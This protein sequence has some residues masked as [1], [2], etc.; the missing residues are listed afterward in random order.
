MFRNF[1]YNHAVCFLS[2]VIPSKQGLDRSLSKLGSP[3]GQT[4]E[5]VS[6]NPPESHS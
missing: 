6:Q 3:K 5:G 4:A 1:A 2:M